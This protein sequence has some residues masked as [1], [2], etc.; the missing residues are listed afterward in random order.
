MLRRIASHALWLTLVVGSVAACDTLHTWATASGG[1]RKSAMDAQSTPRVGDESSTL[2]A[3]D[4]KYIS[5]KHHSRPGNQL[6][7]AAQSNFSSQSGS[8]MGGSSSV[9]TGGGGGGSANPGPSGSIVAP[10][11]LNAK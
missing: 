5:F 1:G 3:E 2:D 10:M 8:G 6:G 11:N 9:D 7:G 4:A